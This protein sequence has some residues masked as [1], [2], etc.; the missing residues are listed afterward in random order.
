MIAPGEPGGGEDEQADGH[1]DQPVHVLDPGE[2]EVEQLRVDVGGKLARLGRR[3]PAAEALGPVRAAEA[4][5]GGAH[6][7]PQADQEEG[8]RRGGDDQFLEAGHF[9]SGFRYW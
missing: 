1:P 2:L 8:H 4:G 6:E 9:R 7:T 5:A 3:N